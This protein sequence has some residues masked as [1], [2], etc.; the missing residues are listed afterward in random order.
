VRRFTQESILLLLA[1]ALLNGSNYLF[2]VAVSR[3]LGPSQYGAL[4]ALLAV[5]MVLSVP[6]GVIQTVVAQR[7]ATLQARGREGEAGLLAAEAMKA[8][9]PFACL[10]GLLMLLAGTPALAIFLHVDTASAALFAPYVVVSVLASVPLGALQGQLRFQALVSASLAGVALRLSSGIALVW[11]GLGVPGAML[12]S[13]LAQGAT[14]ALGILLLRLPRGSWRG[15][16]PTLS[17]LRG[18]F[19]G[20]LLGLGSFW[21]LAEIDIALARHYLDPDPA[22]FYSAAGLIARA[23]L[24]LPAAVSIVAFPRF[25]E[26]RQGSVEEAVRWLRVGLG[27]VGA[28]VLAALPVLVFLRSPLIAIAFGERFQPAASLVPILAVGMGFLALVNLLVFFHVAMGS[29]AYYLVFAGVVVEATLIALFHG[30]GEQIAT[31]VVAVSVVVAALQ[32]HAASALCRWRPLL[33]NPSVEGLSVGLTISD[34]PALELSL[35][36]PCYNA[37]AGLRQLLKGVRRELE[38]TGSYEVIVVS[39]GST[40]ETVSIAKEFSAEAVRLLHYPERAGK[41]NALRVG[42]AQ[43]RGRYVAFIDADGDIGPEAIRPFVALMSLYEPDIVLGSKR[44]PLSEVHY[45]PLRRV[46]SWTYHKLARLLFRVKVSDTQ[47]GLKLIRRDVLAAVLP[48]MLEKRYAFD[49]ELLVVARRLGFKRVFEA[50]V[51]IEYQFGSQVNL[52]AA[53]HILLDTT[54]IFYRR[55]ILNTYRPDGDLGAREAMTSSEAPFARRPV[56]APG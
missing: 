9:I 55:Y 21:L 7:T 54:A 51:R 47:T 11:A 50:P 43:A 14:L 48:R 31:I 26:A 28:L 5:T 49:L 6:F 13:V 8:L 41:G 23:L 30:S 52:G 34:P 10:A 27:A 38:E 39:D 40:D 29:R 24:F 56:A 16:R 4:A 33:W 36:V 18:G 45:P 2:H 35:V 32:Y 42:L 1:L 15:A 37:G 53:L 17:H 19:G 22:G 46:L 25:A 44:H 20:A 3:L 12:A